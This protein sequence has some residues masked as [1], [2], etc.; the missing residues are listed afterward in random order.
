[1]HRVTR[2]PNQPLV[3]MERTRT[4]PSFP[5]RIIYSLSYT[6]VTMPVATYKQRSQTRTCI[7]AWTL[8]FL[9]FAGM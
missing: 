6:C 5:S 3:L 9:F 1:M 2:E 4:R 8:Q 7:F